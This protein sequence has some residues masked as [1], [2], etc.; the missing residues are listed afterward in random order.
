M[1]N[2]EMVAGLVRAAEL[3]EQGEGG[4]LYDDTAR[5]ALERARELGFGASKIGTLPTGKLS[6]SEAVYGVLGWLSSRVTVT[7]LS[8][9]HDS[10]VAAVIADEFCKANNLAPPHGEW[11]K[12]LTHPP[13]RQEHHVESM[14]VGGQVGFDPDRYVDTAVASGLIRK[15][16][17]PETAVP[18]IAPESVISAFFKLC[19][20]RAGLNVFIQDPTAREK[21]LITAIVDATNHALRT[22]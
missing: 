8:Y 12:Y 7:T 15:E 3:K 10:G 9:R 21:A 16:P 2:E 22:R 19:A 4:R 20:N 5:R 13:V 18:Q 14:E 1:T 6:A 17:T 11:S